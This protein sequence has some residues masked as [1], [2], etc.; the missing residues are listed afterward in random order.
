MLSRRSLTTVL[1]SLLQAELLA[2]RGRAN[3][4]AAFPGH[5]PQQWP[6]GLRIGR[7]TA[8]GLGC[9]SLETLWLA[10]AVNEMFHLHEARGEEKLLSDATF[11]D[12][13]E[14]IESAWQSGVA[15]ITFTTSGTTGQPKRCPHTTDALL[16]E[17]SFL[18]DVFRDRRRIVS[19]VPNHHAYGY[20]FT[21]L[22]P[23]ALGISHLDA[24]SLDAGAL[25][26]QLE[27][28]DLIVTFP[29]R[30]RWLERSVRGWA[31]DIEGVVSTALCPPDL[32]AALSDSGLSTMTEVYGSSE[33]IGVA[34]RR[35]P[36]ATYRLMPHWRFVEPVDEDLPEIVHRT[37]QRFHLPDRI[38]SVDQDHFRLAGRLDGAVQ[39][40]GVNV[41]PTRVA[42]RLSERPGV[43]QAAVR[44]MRADE[45]FRLKA[46]IV[47]EPD[48]DLTV[49][50]SDLATWIDV[51]LI[52]A[53][54]PTTITFGPHLPVG[55]MGKAVDW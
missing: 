32:I 44:L 29:D 30:W 5:L 51:K 36:A 31:P 25:S 23:D 22:L 26:R 4:D 37:G 1:Q 19:L 10:S 7:N 17:A 21:A 9:D 38:S 40:G 2:A 16:T 42:D 45:G 49:L 54:R 34:V 11:G 3:P 48:A 27:P 18:A 28:G 46:F 39:V 35:W 33:T 43:R 53:E 14:R 50:R 15:A 52:V 24:T 55:I 20:L 12:W 47:P 13:I 41:L 6:E 8:S